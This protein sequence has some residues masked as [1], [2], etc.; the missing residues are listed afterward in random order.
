MAAG[1]F[2]LFYADNPWT[3]LNKNQRDWLD[4]TLTYMYKR[5]SIF[6]PTISYARDLSRLN[7]T[8]LTVTQLM[9]PH[10]NIQALGARQIWLSAMRIDSRARD[11]TMARYGG[12]TAYHKFDDMVNFWKASPIGGLRQICNRSLGV[13]MVDVLDLLVR[14]AYIAGALQT[15]Y[16]IYEGQATNFNTITPNDVFDPSTAADISL[17]MKYREVPGALGPDGQRNAMV[18][19][20]SPGVTFDIKKDEE[21]IDVRKYAS[22]GSFLNGEVGTYENTRYVE[23]PRLTLWNCGPLIARAPVIEPINAGDGAPDPDTTRVDGV[24]QVG[25]TTTGIKH[26]V[27][28]GVFAVGA[29]AD[30][31]VNDIVSIHFTTTNAYGVPNGVQ[32]Q[33]GALHNLRIVAIDVGNGRITFDRPVMEDFTVQAQG[34][35]AWLTKATH[36]HATIFVGARDGLMAGVGQ[37]PK[38]YAPPPIDD[39]ESIYRFSWDSWIG[40]QPFNPDVWEVVFSSGTVRMKGPKVRQ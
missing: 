36:V 33:E 40:Y 10:P 30:L 20:T 15:G 21:W 27:Q 14:N 31:A 29:I 28:L 37:S 5:R 24:W 2:D 34:R 13:H 1:D 8:R 4:P 18:A 16:V 35:Y 23:D 26:Y 11:I 32:F 17:G 19:F 12:K 9:D 22:P 3:T 7:T 39:F 38:T 25:Q 6:Q